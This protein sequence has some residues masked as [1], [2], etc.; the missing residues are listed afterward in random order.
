[1]I[2]CCGGACAAGGFPSV[3]DW[4]WASLPAQFAGFLCLPPQETQ[5]TFLVGIH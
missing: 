5:G 1:M 3:G 2:Q 4:R